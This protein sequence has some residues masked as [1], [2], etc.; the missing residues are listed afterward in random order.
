[1]RPF[2][3]QRALTL[4]ASARSASSSPPP[5]HPPSPP[6]PREVRRARG[7]PLIE[8][9]VRAGVSETTARVYEAN[10]SAVTPPKREALD[11]VYRAMVED[12]DAK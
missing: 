2:L 9:A 4:A 10:P 11:R 8:A 3:V 1:M 12:D 7:M 6:S 5:P